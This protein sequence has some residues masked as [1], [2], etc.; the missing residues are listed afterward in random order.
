ME[1]HKHCFLVA[2]KLCSK[3]ALQS[4]TF[5]VHPLVA[6]TICNLQEEHDA[7]REWCRSTALT[8]MNPFSLSIQ[9]RAISTFLTDLG[10]SKVRSQDRQNALAA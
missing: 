6:A 3:V 7:A 8:G 5:P 9:Q 4:S 10:G 2:G 1:Q